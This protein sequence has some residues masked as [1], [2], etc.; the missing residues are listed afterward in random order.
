VEALIA[1][2]LLGLFS[3]VAIDRLV[4][5]PWVDHAN[6]RARRGC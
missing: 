3:G 5:V 2:F 1:G 4:L 6:A